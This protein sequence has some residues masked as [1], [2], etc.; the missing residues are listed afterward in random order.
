MWFLDCILYNAIKLIFIVFINK[1]DL[2]ISP[3]YKKN[4]SLWTKFYH[5]WFIM[6]CI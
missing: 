1:I 5:C 4:I 3:N 6:T 2:Q